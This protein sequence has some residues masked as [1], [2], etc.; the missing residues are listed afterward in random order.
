MALRHPRHACCHTCT[1]GKDNVSA[2]KSQVTEIKICKNATHCGSPYSGAHV[3]ETP[4][5]NGWSG[6]A[7]AGNNAS[8]EAEPPNTK[9]GNEA[10]TKINRKQC[11]MKRQQR[12][13]RLIP[14]G[15]DACIIG[16]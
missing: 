9:P 13:V 5:G 11:E 15:T 10:D 4:G 16:T 6:R 1:K 3:L 12:V 7:D 8:S 2:L 14:M